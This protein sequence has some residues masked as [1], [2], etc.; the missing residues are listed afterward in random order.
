MTSRDI[1]G[2]QTTFSYNAENK[3]ATATVG[4]GPI[5]NAYNDD[6]TLMLDSVSWAHYE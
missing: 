1:D 4:S 5:Q 6:G 3:P 2:E